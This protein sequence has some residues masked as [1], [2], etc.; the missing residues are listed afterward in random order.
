MDDLFFGGTMNEAFCVQT[1]RNVFT[2]CLRLHPFSA[3]CDVQ[4][5]GRTS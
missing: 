5:H 1:W 2:A 3:G 4:D